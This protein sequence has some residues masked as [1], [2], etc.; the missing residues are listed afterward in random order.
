MKKI[1][2]LTL[3]LVLSLGL[4]AC[5]GS[6]SGEP[7][8]E[9]TPDNQTETVEIPPVEDLTGVD[10]SAIPG[11]EDGVLTV[12]ME[13]AYAPYNWTQTD[14]SNGAVPIV[15]NPGSYA[16]GY[17]V[18]IA[19]R[20]CDTYGWELEIQSIGWEGLIPALQAGTID[21]VIAGQSMTAERM[22][23]VDMAGPYFY[24]S[25]VCV[26]KADSEQAAA[27]GISELTGTCTAQTG[28][29]WYDSC[30]PQIAGAEI[31]PESETAPAMIMA[32]ASGT[33]DFICTDMPT[34]LGACATYSDLTILDFTGTE[35][36]FTV[37]EG[38]IN[39]GISVL[40][41]N[42]E[43]KDAIDTVMAPLNADIFNALMNQAIAIQPTI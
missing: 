24:A 30:L 20:I 27:K 6:T 29:I 9:E 3:A 4:C 35:D 10:T 32:V 40:K 16:N 28:T 31:M 12:G 5:G 17:D 43:L 22:E 33:V 39:I 41:G 42:T 21:A 26:T 23:Q 36:D 8:P 34:A 11:V 2:A 15:N 25:I 14:D 37:D 13:C 1:L 18:M 19:Q 7:A 38:E